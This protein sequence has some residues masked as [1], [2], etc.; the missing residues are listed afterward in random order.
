MLQK[1]YDRQSAC[2]CFQ[3]CQNTKRFAD[4]NIRAKMQKSNLKCEVVGDGAV[5]KVIIKF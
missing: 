1:K 4:M 5:G 2:I 3:K